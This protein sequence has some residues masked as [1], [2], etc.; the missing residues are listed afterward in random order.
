M[1]LVT[2]KTFKHFEKVHDVKVNILENQRVRIFERNTKIQVI[3][4]KKGVDQVREILL[5]LTDIMD[6]AE[7]STC[8][9]VKEFYR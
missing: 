6:V 1:P 5:G 3:G 7:L 8:E 9:T 2:K 4:S